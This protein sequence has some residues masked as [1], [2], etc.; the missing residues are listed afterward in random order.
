M[1]KRLIFL[2]CICL[3]YIQLALLRN[4]FCL[5]VANGVYEEYRLLQVTAVILFQKYQR[6]VGQY[7]LWLER[8]WINIVKGNII[9]S[10]TF[11]FL[12]FS[13]FAKNL[14]KINN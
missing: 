14:N 3:I 8:D 9:N 13:V 4:Q 10:W 7:F 6:L 1:V 2:Q 12:K 11:Y 5:K